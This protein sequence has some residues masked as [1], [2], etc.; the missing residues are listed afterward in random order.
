[1]SL[2]PREA[3]F[4]GSTIAHRLGTWG[5]QPWVWVLLQALAIW[6]FLA[7][8]GRLEPHHHIDSH[9]YVRLAK[10]FSWID[11]LGSRRTLGYPLFLRALFWLRGDLGWLPHL[12]VLSLGAAAVLW[13]AALQRF[14]LSAPAA[15]VAGSWPLY[16]RLFRVLKASVMTDLP[17]A[18]LALF[19][20]AA[21]LF[22]LCEPRRTRWWAGLGVLLFL[23]YQVRP[24]YASLVLFLPLAAW[25]SSRLEARWKLGGEPRRG[26]VSRLG[27]LM[28][29]PLLLFCACRWALVGHFGLVAF[30]GHNLSGL[31]SSMLSPEL[32]AELPAAEQPLAA[33]ILALRQ[34]KGLAPLDARSRAEEWGRFYNW[35]CWEA[36]VRLVRTAWKQDLAEASAR[37][38]IRGTAVEHRDIYVERRLLPL[39]VS[40]LRARPGLYLVWMSRGWTHAL[41]TT[42]K[43]PWIFI[44]AVLLGLSWLLFGRLRGG[45]HRQER[46]R[47]LL[48]LLLAL[49]YYL[50]T[51]GLVLLVEIAD[52]RYIAAAELLLPGAMLAMAVELFRSGSGRDRLAAEAA[53]TISA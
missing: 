14:G 28:C 6:G 34:E 4:F 22:L 19:A 39:S 25:V 52:W 15:L 13:C 43:Q 31:T 35:N 41:L 5:R 38:P 33:A 42:G 51:M 45:A 18:T 7:F 26:L 30:T 32:V 17:A 20:L 29:G 3:W 24:S 21:L 53:A 44:P 10:D 46:G 40:I 12:Q 48:V 11:I 1:M 8:Q 16:A 47:C 23:A 2:G 36:A 27:L 49:A 50:A 9:F 37:G